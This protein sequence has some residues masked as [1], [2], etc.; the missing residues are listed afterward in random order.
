MN[1]TERMMADWLHALFSWAYLHL[2][3]LIIITLLFWILRELIYTRVHVRVGLE[4]LGVFA[5]DM[6][7]QVKK[8]REHLDPGAR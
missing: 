7:D 4:A 3:D 2:T 5:D 6:H 8:I 1:P